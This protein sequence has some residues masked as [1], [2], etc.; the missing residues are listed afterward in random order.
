MQNMDD[1][2]LPAP[3]RVARETYE[4][5]EAGEKPHP[6]TRL[7]RRRARSFDVSR[8]NEQPP[9]RR[10]KGRSGGWFFCKKESV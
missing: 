8:P 7:L 1:L 5:R 3:A 2:W 10:E 4:E 9:E 6:P